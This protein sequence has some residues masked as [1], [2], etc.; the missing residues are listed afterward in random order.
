MNQPKD[1]LDLDQD[2]K[3]KKKTPGDQSILVSACKNNAIKSQN[4]DDYVV[5][6]EDPK[7]NAPQVQAPKPADFITVSGK[8]QTEDLFLSWNTTRDKTRILWVVSVDSFKN[9][10]IKNSETFKTQNQMEWQLRIEQPQE[11]HSQSKKTIQ[12]LVLSLFTD[13]E[14]QMAAKRNFTTNIK[15]F[16]RDSHGGFIEEGKVISKMYSVDKD[17]SLGIAIERDVI[18]NAR[19]NQIVFEVILVAKPAT[20]KSLENIPYFGLNNAGQTCYMN[21][22]LQTLFH[23]K[24]L[25]KLVFKI[26][27]MDESKD[28]FP[29]A[30]QEL[31]FKL[32][33][34]NK[35][36]D[37][38]SLIHTYGWNTQDVRTPRARAP[39]CA[40]RHSIDI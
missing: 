18:I 13:M 24:Q 28:K 21:S 17:Q 15:V 29:K 11:E 35:S 38:R 39:T 40:S 23:L 30:L 32:I 10:S 6:I 4:D 27:I 37:T 3:I 9:T 22:Y 19:N 33:K 14:V 1:E 8:T 5:V 31:F 16:Y 20:G 2:R 25:T 7:I 26:Q 34:R 12:F 36:Q